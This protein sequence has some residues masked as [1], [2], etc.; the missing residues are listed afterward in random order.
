MVGAYN[1][2][3][4][5]FEIVPQR[6][7]RDVDG[8]QVWKITDVNVNQQGQVPTGDPENQPEPHSMQTKS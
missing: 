6:H 1:V 7:Y 5:C 3:Y 8:W 2:D 4:I